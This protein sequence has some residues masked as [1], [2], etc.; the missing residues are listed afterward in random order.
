MVTLFKDLY[1][2]SDTPHHM[3]ISKA[4]DRIK[5]G[6][7]KSIIEAI[8]NS[9]VSKEKDT[10][11]KKLPSI[12]FAGKFSARNKDSCE[13]HSG[14]MITDFDDIPNEEEYN[15]VF[16]EVKSNPH[17][18]AIFRSPSGNGFKPIVRI[19]QCDKFDHE[20][21]FKAFAKEFNYDYFDNSNCDISRVC[22]E[23]Y[24]PDLYINEK[25]IVYSPELIDDGFEVKEYFT[26]TPLTDE[27]EI[28][29][30]IMKWDW[31]K[32]FVHGERNNFIFDIAGAF[33]EFGVSESTAL[34]YIMNNVVSGDFSEREATNTIKNVYRKR[35][36]GSRVFEDYNK[37]KKLKKDVLSKGKEE[38]IKEYDLSEKEYEEI[39]DKA[40]QDTFWYFEENSKGEI[41]TKIDALKYKFFLERN[42]FKKYF[43]EG[44][45]TPTWVRI[46]SN[47]VSE[48]S[49]EKIKDFVL[50]YLLEAKEFSVWSYC[51]SFHNIFSENFLLMLESIDL[52]M[53]RDEKEKSYI[54]YKNGI[55][56]VTKDNINLIDYIDVDGY[57]W[58]RHIIQREFKK[59]DN[60]DNDYKRF[61]NN[62]SNNNPEPIESVIGYLMSTYKNKMNNRAVILNDEVISDNPEGG[63]GK[64]LFIQGIR[65][66]RQVSILDGKTFDDK[67]SFPYQTISQ[68]TQV[69]V[70][71]DVKKNWDFESKFSI[72]TEGITLERKNKDAIKLSVEDSP[73]MV[74]STNYAIKG[75]GNSHD[76]RR[77]EI[78]VSQYYG[79][80]LTPYDEFGR[81]VFDD[82]NESDF[83]AFDNYMVDCLVL[84]LNK[85][86]IKQD[87]K[88]LSMRKFIAETNMEFY[89]WATSTE[90]NLPENRRLYKNELYQDFI[91]NYPDYAHGRFKL[92][93][94]S[95]KMY[96]DSYAKWFGYPT[97][98]PK[99]RDQRGRYVEFIKDGSKPTETDEDDFTPID[100]DVPF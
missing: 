81:Q 76:R 95:F 62:I 92:S 66:M 8:R 70:F 97:P 93:Q 35:A 63:T 11:K 79:R 14:Y 74:V 2:S 22:F 86:L 42:G 64:G 18:Y 27:T 72:V 44:S 29:E 1:N 65:N 10:L 4:L 47:R 60:K 48:T 75:S 51:A 73:K 40:Q 91:S 78:E 33:C 88:N 68:D 50:D 45:Q 37:S 94:R 12:L 98:D 15:R 20:R 9:K 57:I 58:E 23:S 69:L 31:S 61:I 16:E 19:P 46:Q 43:P 77:H 7:S 32:D 71:D 82:W 6:S 26:Y 5:N 38:I 55:L 30:R 52:M 54:A 13:Q 25:A 17:V 56:E 100:G 59:V 39:R 41:K 3:P 90:N 67:K 53:L 36:F 49:V 99:L 85:G 87:S 80:D 34:G 96:L 84:Y 28:I 83:L 24:D 21:Y 89:Q